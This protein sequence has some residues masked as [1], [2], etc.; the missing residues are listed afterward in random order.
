[1]SDLIPHSSACRRAS[2]VGDVV[3]IHGLGGNAYKYWCHE[4]KDKNFWPSWLKDSLPNVGIWSYGYQAPWNLWCGPTTELRERATECLETLKTVNIGTRSL[5]FVAHSLGGL[6]VKRVLL[7]SLDSP[8]SYKKAFAQ[9]V[10]GICFLATPHH[11]ADIA[12][13]ITALGWFLPILRLSRSVH[14]LKRNNLDLLDQNN[15]FRRLVEETKIA[16]KVLCESFP[17]SRYGLPRSLFGVMVVPKASADPGLSSF[18][19]VS[20][21]H[22]HISICK[23]K[24]D[25]DPLY[26][27][28]LQFIS[29]LL[30]PP[31]TPDH[32]PAAA[33]AHDDGPSTSPNTINSL[34]GSLTPVAPPE[35][36]SPPKPARK[37]GLD[38]DKPIKVRK[39]R[40]QEKLEDHSNIANLAIHPSGDCFAFSQDDHLYV[41]GMQLEAVFPETF[42]VH[43]SPGI[44]VPPIDPQP[45]EQ[46][47][48]PVRGNEFIATIVEKLVDEDKSPHRYRRITAISFSPSGR[49]LI[50]ADRDGQICAWNF[51]ER[52]RIC[53]L[54]EHGS[55]VSALAFSPKGEYLATASYDEIINIWDF[56]SI[57]NGKPALV[58]ELQKQSN[59][60]GPGKHPHEVERI[61]S[62]AFTADGKHL[63]SGDQKGLV[64]VREVTT[65]RGMFRKTLHNGFVRA[66][67][68][69]P[70]D[71]NLLATASDDSRIR[72][73]W[74]DGGRSRTETLGV[75]E[76]KHLDA[77]N[78]IAF[79]S[80]GRILVSSAM[81]A[82]VRIWSIEDQRLISTLVSRDGTNVDRV[83]FFPNLYNFATD[84]FDRDIRLW[85]LSNEGE[86]RKTVFSFDD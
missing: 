24:H 43:S 39:F 68:F 81:D 10:K 34:L 48:P 13:V 50:S 19:V 23:P 57:I 4:G 80:C 27:G 73:T 6:L 72:L 38:L 75:K 49:Y 61:V 79:S 83:A 62:I 2:R 42:G 51:A 32:K 74:I 5:V 21:D 22:D 25:R 17:T 76:E 14:E 8:D 77:L 15:Q 7:S 63:A 26:L 59:K 67:C 58:Q 55:D 84:A 41:R 64:R 54:P 78:S 46:T 36:D 71:P 65:R 82:T 20:V 31:E 16:G 18:D 37:R 85:E 86:I 45:S 33:N 11:G 53:M 1:M 30:I 9:K 3:F 60:K 12:N 70:V 29:G 35:S 47:P 44:S 66:I 56:S 28:T 69:S 40:T 52:R